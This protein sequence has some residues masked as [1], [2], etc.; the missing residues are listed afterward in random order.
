MLSVQILQT[1]SVLVSP[2][3]PYNPHNAGRMKV[4]GLSVP[5][6]KKVW[7]PVLCFLIRHP[8]GTILV[9]TG[10]HRKISPT[11]EYDPKAQRVALYSRW[12]PVVNKGWLP[13]GKAIDEQ[14]AQLGVSVHDLDYVILTH[15]DCDNVSGLQQ[16]KEAKHILVSDDEMAGTEGGGF[17]NQ[18]RYRK[19]FWE[20]VPL[21]KYQWNDNAGPFNRS[22]DLFGDRSIELIAIPGHS[23]GMVAVK[24]NNGDGKY[25]LLTAD[26]AYSQ[27]CWREMVT[28]GIFVDRDDQMRSLEWIRERSLS[29]DCVA[30]I[31]THEP[32][33]E[34]RTIEF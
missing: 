28:P 18:V 4:F 34:L 22:Y 32:D 2:Y 3:V 9:D 15:L 27:R 12:L 23:A 1:G 25:V 7:M 29:P 17:A 30:S 11:G 5:N 24:I 31:A 14:L 6:D 21:T 13:E 8:R 10:W 16:V 20:K 19:A 26:G 33:V